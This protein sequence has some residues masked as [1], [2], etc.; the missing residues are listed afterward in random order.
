[1]FVHDPS[2]NVLKQAIIG[3]RFQYYSLG[4]KIKSLPLFESDLKWGALT[5][6]ILF[7]SC[8]TSSACAIVMDLNLYITDSLY[9]SINNGRNVMYICRWGKKNQ[10]HIELFILWP[11][12]HCIMSHAVGWPN[13][14]G[15]PDWFF[16]RI[17]KNLGGEMY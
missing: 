3:N 17:I 13:L 5:F 1:M 8:R 12:R 10:F 7:E 9:R 4:N 6:N 14:L 16:F 2:E 15:L 11:F